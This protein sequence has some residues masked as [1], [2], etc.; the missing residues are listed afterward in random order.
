[1]QSGFS[2]A[3]VP[4]VALYQ[5]RTGNPPARLRR[6]NKTPGAGRKIPSDAT[7]HVSACSTKDRMAP[8]KGLDARLR[9][10]HPLSSPAD[11]RHRRNRHD[12]APSRDEGAGT[13]S[14]SRFTTARP[15]VRPRFATSD[16]H[17]GRRHFMEA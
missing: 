8:H 15:C 10:R 2:A 9:G 3:R 1:V 11:D 14:L 5:S 4:A 17:S 7:R 13:A 6:V 12:A 16:A